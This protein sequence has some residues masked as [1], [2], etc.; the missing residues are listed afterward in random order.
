MRP[1]RKLS[2]KGAA[3]M[4]FALREGGKKNV[5]VCFSSPIS[6]KFSADALLIQGYFKETYNITLQYPEMMCVEVNLS[7]E[8]SL[9]LVKI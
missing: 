5:A 4:V 6:R 2:D 7:P 3:D 1:V 9:V 8:L